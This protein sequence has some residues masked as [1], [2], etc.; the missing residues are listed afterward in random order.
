MAAPKL[1]LILVL[2]ISG[3]YALNPRW[4]FL[5]KPEA[6]KSAKQLPYFWDP[7]DPIHAWVDF[8][9]IPERTHRQS[10]DY[11]LPPPP[12]WYDTPDPDG[13]DPDFELPIPE[14]PENPWWVDNRKLDRRA[15]K[16]G[17]FDKPRRRL[18]KLLKRE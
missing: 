4:D 2:F 9:S 14:L 13:F 15:S 11:Y 12:G 16:L 5:L 10:D 6:E 17:N 18:E 3:N 8:H 7:F 1:A